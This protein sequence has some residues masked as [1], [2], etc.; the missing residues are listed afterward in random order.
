MT[1]FPTPEMSPQPKCNNTA[2]LPCYPSVPTLT[3]S[4]APGPLPSTQTT[5]VIPLFVQITEEF[6]LLL[7]NMGVPC[8]VTLSHGL[9]I[10]LDFSQVLLHLVLLP[11]QTISLKSPK[12][13]QRNRNKGWGLTLVL[14][15]A[16]SPQSQPTRTAEYLM[17]LIDPSHG[18]S[19]PHT[20]IMPHCNSVHIMASLV[21]CSDPQ[22]D[23]RT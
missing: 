3:C 22:R 4:Q 8:P 15:L 13:N 14:S 5:P 20:S 12:I 9:S 6:V 18:L 23:S 2:C 19:S 11:F 7:I 17:D 21:F 16:R 10:C 1:M